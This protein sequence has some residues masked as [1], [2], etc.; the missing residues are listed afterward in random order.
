MNRRISLIKGH[1][2]SAMF[3][4]NRI[5]SR[6]HFVECFFPGYGFPTRGRTSNRRPQAIGILVYIRE[7]HRFGANMTAA[8]G[9]LVV[10]FD[11]EDLLAFVLDDDATHRLAEIARS[12]VFLARAHGGSLQSRSTAERIAASLACKS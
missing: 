12:E 1:G 4:T 6:G 10:A 9:V 5:Q 8:E 3:F 11:R 2:M 7:G